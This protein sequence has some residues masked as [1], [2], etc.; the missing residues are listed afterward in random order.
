MILVRLVQHVHS[1]KWEELESVDSKFNAIENRLGYPPK[2][3]YRMFAGADDSDT[4]V[5]ER[6]WESLA[7]METDLT[8]AMALPD[9]QRL[10]TETNGLIDSN[11]WEFYFV[12]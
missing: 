4:L 10:L 2:R 5:I 9:Y 6:E 3:R 12:L 7:A 8:K 1:G 11:R